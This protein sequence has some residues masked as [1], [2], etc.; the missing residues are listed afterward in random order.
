MEGNTAGF[1]LRTRVDGVP[2]MDSPIEEPQYALDEA[3]AVFRGEL[4]SRDPVR[5]LHAMRRLFCAEVGLNRFATG[6]AG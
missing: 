6:I 1:D 4:T 5:R 3:E 2:W